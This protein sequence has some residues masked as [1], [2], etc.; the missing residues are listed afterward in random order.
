MRAAALVA[1]LVLLGAVAVSSSV[2]VGGGAVPVPCDFVTSGGFVLTP[3][4]A[5]ANFGAHGGCKKGAFWGHVNYI[6]HGMG[7]HV[8]ST[9][10]TGYLTPAPLSNV[11]DICGEASHVRPPRRAVALPATGVQELLEQLL[12]TL[13][14]AVLIA[15]T[16]HALI[17][18][19]LARARECGVTTVCTAGRLW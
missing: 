3:A 18:L 19:A 11:R 7:L 1:A 6:D 9:Q 5:M 4:E 8:D 15:G 17:W 13:A 10:I 12:D 2:P 14:P 16:A